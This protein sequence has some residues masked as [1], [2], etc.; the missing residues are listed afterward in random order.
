MNGHA[1]E[2][3]L[4]AAEE[5]KACCASA[6]ESEAVR[7]L[8][9]GQLHPGGA[10]LTLR[11][12][13]LAGVEAGERVL[14]VASGTGAT[15]RLLAHEL[16]VEAVGVDYGA[17]AV[18]RAQREAE[19]E[20]CD[21]RVAFVHGDAEALPFADDT[22]DIA[23]CECSLCT[24]PDKRAAIG[25]MARVLRPGGRVAISD[26]TANLAALPPPLRTAAAQVACVADAL[27]R[28]GYVA[29]VE[30]AGFEIVAV[31]DHGG[32][33][34]AMIERVEARLR[35]AR[36]LGAEQLGEYADQ[37]EQGIELVRL[38]GRELAAGR[39]GYSLFVA[40]KPG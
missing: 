32:A 4:L 40:R 27:P 10:G 11:A 28:A 24:F 39:L 1:E 21:D 18:T 29:L 30:S 33:L 34:A 31:E 36:I 16:G 13:A 38:A 19:A 35:A 15:A 12:A 7:W 22:F 25:E 14:D 26:M 9:G 23:V 17:E 8:L 2:V 20:G 5:A 3:A 37:L 6:Y